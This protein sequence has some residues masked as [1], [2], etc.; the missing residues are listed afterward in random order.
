MSARTGLSLDE[1]LHTSFDD[2]DPEFRDGELVE[3][4]PADTVHGRAHA[5]VGAFFVLRCRGL[6]VFPCSSVRL[7]VREELYLVPDISVFWPDEPV[8]VFPDQPPLVVIEILSEDDRL[9]AVRSKLDEYRAWGVPHVWL[10]DPYLRKLYT[11][12]AGLTEV[13]ALCVPE[14]D[15]ELRPEHIFE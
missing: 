13:A 6:H 15:L 9:T 1:Y 14:L 3:R 8:L 12:D 7:K 11:C 10:V 4:S 5:C 2:S